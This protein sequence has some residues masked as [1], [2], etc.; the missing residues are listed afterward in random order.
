[1]KLIA[2]SVLSCST[3]VAATLSTAAMAQNSP[4]PAGQVVVDSVNRLYLNP[5]TTQ[6]LLTGYFASI[7]GLPGPLFSGVPSESTAHFTW[8]SASSGATVLP[9]GDIAGVVLNSGENFNV[10]YNP[11]PNQN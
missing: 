5:V 4:A 2:M 10:Y 8:S 6:V 11:S 9:N 7:E 1:M 3:W